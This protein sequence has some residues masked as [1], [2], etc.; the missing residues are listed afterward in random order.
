MKK[1]RGKGRSRRNKSM[2]GG[3]LSESQ[4]KERAVFTLMLAAVM[5]FAQSRYKYKV[6]DILSKNANTDQKTL[7]VRFFKTLIDMLLDD[8]LVPED[9]K[10]AIKRIL[11]YKLYNGGPMQGGMIGGLG[12]V[13]LFYAAAWIAAN[14]NISVG[15]SAAGAALAAAPTIGFMAAG[16]PGAAIGF[17]LLQGAQ[18][19]RWSEFAPS[20]RSFYP[21]GSSSDGDPRL[22]TWQ[23]DGSDTA[24]ATTP[25][26]ETRMAD[27]T[28]AAVRITMG[29]FPAIM[30]RGALDAIDSIYNSDYSG[31]YN[32]GRVLSAGVAGGP[33]A[34]AAAAVGMSAAGFAESGG[35]RTRNKRRR[36]SKRQSRS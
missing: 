8:N 30:A 18:P 3:T 21:V 32:L 27:L 23:P 19:I 35:R 33:A 7:Q 11:D 14:L 1:T 24:Q 2:R 22:E 5:R 20:D 28:V 9:L 36:S 16:P 12:P 17:I 26:E 10:I 25:E 6:N 15:P 13:S 34:A 4:R 31:V 29:P